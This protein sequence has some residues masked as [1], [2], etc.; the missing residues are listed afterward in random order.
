MGPTPPVGGSGAAGGAAVDVRNHFGNTPLHLVAYNSGNTDTARLLI[1]NGANIESRNNLELRQQHLTPLLAAS[2]NGQARLV[3]LLRDHGANTQAT[4]MQGGTA[5]HLA[6]WKGHMEVA[7]TLIASGVDV[8]ARDHDGNTPLS[9]ADY[10]GHS[11]LVR[12]LR[13]RGATN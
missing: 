10:Y 4:S 5:L 9:I 1:A 11:N 12:F 6:A 2:V 7:R 13:S 8:N 3:E